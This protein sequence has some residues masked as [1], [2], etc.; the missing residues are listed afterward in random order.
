[1]FE[2]HAM[3]DVYIR[4]GLTPRRGH[5]RHTWH[6]LSVAG[7]ETGMTGRTKVARRR[8]WRRKPMNGRSST[9]EM[10][11]GHPGVEQCSHE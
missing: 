3:G 6:D 10:M 8:L 4:E 11:H 9:S 2:G 7:T 5:W 1:M